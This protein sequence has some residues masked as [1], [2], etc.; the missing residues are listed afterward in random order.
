MAEDMV[1]LFSTGK[2]L[3]IPLDNFPELLALN[4]VERKECRLINNGESV[5]WDY[6][7]FEISAKDLLRLSAS[8]S[9]DEEEE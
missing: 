5:R 6:I 2:K 4:N 7:E 3:I 1:A 9:S 8:D